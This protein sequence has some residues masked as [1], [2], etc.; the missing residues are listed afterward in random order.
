[1]PVR[2]VFQIGVRWRFFATPL[3]S[4]L[5]VAIAAVA[6]AVLFTRVYPGP[7]YAYQIV[8]GDQLYFRYATHAVWGELPY[9]SI[10]MEY[11]PL[12]LVPFGLPRLL[13]ADPFVWE[14]LY[15]WEMLA[16]SW[17]ALALLGWATL[18]QGRSLVRTLGLYLLALV[19]I[20]PLITQRYDLVPAVLALLAMVAYQDGR[21]REAWLAVAVGAL[22]KLYSLVLVPLF[23][24]DL[25]RRRERGALLFGLASLAA[26]S[27]AAAA[28]VVFLPMPMQRLFGYHWGRGAEVE[29]LY[30]NLGLLA[31]VLGGS[32]SAAYY[33]AGSVNLA[34]PLTDALTPYSTAITAAG[35]LSV[36]AAYY[37]G[38]PRHRG[39]PRALFAYGTASILVFILG[40][41][42]L[43]P[44][45]LIWLL[46]L[47]PLAG[48]GLANLLFLVAAALTALIYPAHFQEFYTATPLVVGMLTARNLLLIAVCFLLLGDRRQQGAPVDGRWLPL[49]RQVHR[50]SSVALAT[51]CLSFPLLYLLPAPPS[52]PVYGRPDY[53]HD[54]EVSVLEAYVSWRGGIDYDGNGEIDAQEHRIF[55]T[56]G[57][58]V[59]DDGF[60]D[61]DEYRI[62]FNQWPPR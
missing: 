7:L 6:S 39:Q 29:S 54:G 14:R 34:A 52:I 28:G 50:G 49:L 62:F 25:W 30:A 38:W 11:P 24:I 40:N 35:L 55:L 5:L 18:R 23:L 56:R 17:L 12:A 36:Y 43:S 61:G 44:Q 57:L 9:V 19:A 8:G 3:G 16:W 51:F 45:Y 59:L 10:G 21:Y 41:K 31:H 48:S 60:I 37:L 42:V 22:T 1:M 53:D 47:L 2:G 33:G 58:D 4:R 15:T 20:G 27:L 32:P 13:T 26:L 46:P